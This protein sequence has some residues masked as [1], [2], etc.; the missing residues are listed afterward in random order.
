MNEN[1]NYNYKNRKQKLKYLSRS[2]KFGPLHE[3]TRFEGNVVVHCVNGII[4]NADVT[5]RIRIDAVSIMAPHRIENV[6]IFYA[7]VLT[8]PRMD[9]VHRRILKSQIGNF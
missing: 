3:K 7:H 2:I 1:K 8:V 6:D 9:V 4:Y 5:A